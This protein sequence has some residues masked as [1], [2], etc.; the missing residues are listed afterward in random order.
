MRKSFLRVIIPVYFLCLLFV[1]TA[2]RAY[3]CSDVSEFVVGQ[4]SVG[5]VYQNVG[6][7]FECLHSWCAWAKPGEDSWAVY[8]WEE[9]GRCD[10]EPAGSPPEAT[11]SNPHGNTLSLGNA[12]LFTGSVTDV[13]SDIVSYT[14]AVYTNE[15]GS[16]SQP[17]ILSEGW[18]EGSGQFDIT[19]EWIPVYTGQ[20]ALV[21]SA[22]DA[23]GQTGSDQIDVEVVDGMVDGSPTLTVVHPNEIALGETITVTTEFFHPSANDAPVVSIFDPQGTAIETSWVSCC[24]NPGPQ[25]SIVIDTSATPTTIGEYVVSVDWAVAPELNQNSTFI[26][27]DPDGLESPTFSIAPTLGYQ[28]QRGAFSYESWHPTVEGA[29][30][31]IMTGPDGSERSIA[32]VGSSSASGSGGPNTGYQNERY[33]DTFYMPTSIGEYVVA[34]NFANGDTLETTLE[35]VSGYE[36]EPRFSIASIGNLVD[37]ESVEISTYVYNIYRPETVEVLVDGGSIGFNGTIPVNSSYEINAQH[38]WLAEAGSHTITARVTNDRGDVFEATKEIE[39]E[40]AQTTGDCD[41]AGVDPASVNEYPNWTARDWPGGPYNHA[42]SGQLMSYQGEVFQA[43][44]YTSVVP[45]SD[46]SWTYICAL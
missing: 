35:V 30:E 7:A 20:Y 31:L 33:T 17:E 32:W 28:G 46:A 9:L 39:V 38:S 43:N 11:A 25:S 2:V 8:S 23:T 6:K 21:V 19:G 29:P 3:N 40:A 22:T 5:Q 4:A 44:W 18:S 24:G 15:N 41:A 26:V 45:G 10:S 14:L 16:L 34:A 36:A 37:G 12:Y 1:S 27:S 42:N 13:D